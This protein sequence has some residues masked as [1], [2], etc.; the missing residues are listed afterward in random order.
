MNVCVLGC[1]RQGMVAAVEL[2]QAHNVTVL[3]INKDNLKRLKGLPGIKA[4][5]FDVTEKRRFCT[6]LKNFDIVLGT[7]PSPLGFYS[8]ECALRAK[9][10][11]VDMSYLPEDPFTLDRIA[12][13]LKVRIVVD[14]GFAPGLSNI[15][16]GECYRELGKIDT[17]KIMV[18]GIPQNPVPPFNYRITWSPADLV[19]EYTRPARIV[20]NYKVIT[21]PPLSGI[22]EFSLAGVGRLECFYTDGLRTLLKTIKG[23]MD[24]EEKTIRY[25]G[26][27]ELFKSLIDCKLFS[28]EV[29]GL[30]GNRIKVKDFTIEF[31]KNLLSRG[32]EMDISILIIKTTAGKQRRRYLILDRYDKKKK[33]T[34]MARM[35]AYT[36]AAIIEVIKKYPSYG[37]IP[38]EYLGFEKNLCPEIK[39]ILRKKGI[40][41]P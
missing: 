3:D 36:G 14:A 20:K 17:L 13:R 40:N 38:P 10:N 41:I 25:P 18:G 27:A 19:E 34:S 35:T 2:A 16:I 26:H 31:L 15:L 32:D 22:E 6:L 4:K 23:T 37:V 39:K 24:M 8:I 21:V 5:E 33:I 1:G 29:V 28:E 9:R 12:K 30:N 11:M 7:L